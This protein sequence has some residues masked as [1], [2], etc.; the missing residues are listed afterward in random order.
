[1]EKNI[2]SNIAIIIILSG[3]AAF[4]GIQNYFQ[5]V[6]AQKEMELS[7]IQQDQKAIH[8]NL[9]KLRNDLSKSKNKAVNEITKQQPPIH[10]QAVVETPFISNVHDLVDG[11]AAIYEKFEQTHGAM[12]PEMA[13][14]T[15]SDWISLAN[16][17]FDLSNPEGVQRA[18][19]Q[20]RQK[21]KFKLL[22]RVSGTIILG[23]YNNIPIN[24][25]DEILTY[26]QTNPP[27]SGEGQVTKAMLDRYEIPPKDAWPS[28]VSKM[29][30]NWTNKP[31]DY[32]ILEKGSPSN[33]FDSPFYHLKSGNSGETGPLPDR[34]FK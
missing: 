20:T 19:T 12:I 23:K 2:K 33:G 29:K 7:K 5:N 16:E 14:L 32:L 31:I 27:P 18:L 22:G 8:S 4:I 34:F 28:L 24:N 15:K 10:E 11:A 3:A 17:K 13:L 1:M 26:L 30:P 9:E 6:F 21:A 25:L